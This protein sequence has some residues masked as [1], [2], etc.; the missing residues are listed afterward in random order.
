[1]PTERARRLIEDLHEVHSLEKRWEIAE[2][3]LAEAEFVCAYPARN[4]RA[5]W[6]ERTTSAFLK[7]YGPFAGGEPKEG[8]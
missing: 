5:L 1:M 6:E 2:K 8:A 4:L 3:Y 7:H